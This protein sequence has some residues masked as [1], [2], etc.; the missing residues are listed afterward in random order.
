LPALLRLRAL[1]RAV[2][3]DLV[4]AHSSKAGAL[5]RV[6]A[7]CGLRARVF[8]TPHAYYRMHAPEGLKARF[9][10]TIERGLGG[11]GTT[12]AVSDDEAA[13]ARQRLGVAENDQRIVI[14]GVDCAR[15]RP[16]EPRE[17]EALRAQ[18]GLSPDAL[19]LGTVGRFSAQKDPLTTY[20][21]LSQMMAEE[22]RLHF[23]H[24]GKGELEPEVDELLARSGLA[25]RCHRLPYLADTAPFYR[26]LDGFLLASLYEGMSYAV[27]EAIA[28]NL[29]LILTD[30]PGN[31]AFASTGLD[32]IFWSAPGDAQALAGAMREWREQFLSGG[33]APGHRAVATQRF[34]DRELLFRVAQGLSRRVATRRLARRHGCSVYAISIRAVGVVVVVVPAAARRQLIEDQTCERGTGADQ[35]LVG[36]GYRFAGRARGVDHEHH[37][38]DLTRQQQSVADRVDRRG[39]HHDS[40]VERRRFL[41]HLAEPRAG[42]HFRRI[43]RSH[44][45]GQHGK[46]RLPGGARDFA[47][48]G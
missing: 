34:F 2:G 6:L 19:I 32:R 16:A 31:R 46:F 1:I 44:S 35:F 41:Q 5:V 23:L 7:R 3:P 8:Y 29:P 42:Q 37:G 30:A 4:H 38:V 18:F 28:S 39:I 11:C 12:I 21:A 36:P 17:K 47:Q 22:P 43:P 26:A 14:N 10:H 15:F 45:H 27:L 33:Q 13:F 40:I 48:R 25:A 24:V 20:T 9:F